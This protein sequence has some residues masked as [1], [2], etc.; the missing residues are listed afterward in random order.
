MSR[1]QKMLMLTEKGYR[2]LKRGI[3]ACV[4]TNFSRFLPFTVIMMSISELLRGMDGKEIRTE[5]LLSYLCLGGVSTVLIFLAGRNDY[6]KTYLA[7]Y[8][9][10]M[11]TRIGIAEHLR[12][13]PMSFFE[14]KDLS[15]LSTHFMGDI[16][17][18]EQVMSHLIP[19]MTANLITILVVCVLLAFQEI[20]LAAAIFSTVPAAFLLIFAGRKMQIRLGEKHGKAKLRASKEIQEFL[21]GIKVI[22]A[23]NLDSE[24]FSALKNALSEMRRMAIQYELNAGICVAGAQTVLQIGIGITVL[25]SAKFLTN[26][27]ISFFTV[28]VFMMIVTRVYGPILTE[29]TL[30]PEFLYHRVAMERLQRL[31]S[32]KEISGEERTKPE[33]YTVRFEN[34][35][36]RY[37]AAKTEAIRN[38][39]TTIAQGEV[40]ALVGASGSGKTTFAKLIGR[41]GELESGKIT[42][43]GIDIREWHPEYL[44]SQLSFVFQ[45]VLLFNDT[46]YSNIRIGKADATEEEVKAAAVAACCHEFIEE[47]PQGYDTVLGENGAMLSGGERQRL[48]I[49]RALLKNAPIV[50]LDEATSSL[51][52]ENGSRIQRALSELIR[53]KTVLVIA[54]RLNTVM[55]ADHIIVLE[56]GEIEE[57]GTHQK[58]MAKRGLYYKLFDLEQKSMTWHI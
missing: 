7:S 21:D 26:G 24:K 49:A 22:K 30:L 52:A 44:L 1:F 17:S 10:S 2:D 54:H 3:L 56:N 23:C 32:T 33:S 4:L 19:Q 13:L 14:A 51:D 41:F 35:R 25:L 5:K 36:F 29:L 31:M 8:R 57:E 11:N 27:E 43:G 6:K 39:S 38:V 15:E 20:R 50:I 9:E 46:V 48:S 53:N 37:P 28:I 47:L 18:C 12:K 40:T 42:V 34:V 16:A 45:D 55:N 58:L